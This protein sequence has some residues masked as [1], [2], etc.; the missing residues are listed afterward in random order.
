MDKNEYINEMLK[1]N[2]FSILDLVEYYDNNKEKIDSFRSIF[3]EKT[4]ADTKIISTIPLIL[5]PENAQQ[6]QDFYN[7]RSKF[8]SINYEE[9][10]LPILTAL[11]FN[12]EFFVYACNWCSYTLYKANTISVKSYGESTVRSNKVDKKKTTISFIWESLNIQHQQV[13]AQAA[14]TDDYV[15]IYPTSTD[16]KNNLLVYW[17]E[18]DNTMQFIYVFDDNYSEKNTRIKIVLKGLCDLEGNEIPE[19]ILDSE[20]NELNEVSKKI[21][22][23]FSKDFEIVDVFIGK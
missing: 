7:P 10:K 11:L 21:K 17:Y 16:S 4:E 13:F 3:D 19:V 8:L 2:N 20:L 6:I 18:S 9:Y 14:A 15:Q 23:N 5:N 22:A 12:N 1:Q